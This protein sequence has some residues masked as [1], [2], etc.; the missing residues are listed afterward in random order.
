MSSLY[1]NAVIWN[2]TVVAEPA[3]LTQIPLRLS[4]N[5]NFWEDRTQAIADLP[6]GLTDKA[7]PNYS[8]PSANDAA[9]NEKYVV[10]FVDFI[11][12]MLQYIGCWVDQVAICSVAG[13]EHERCAD[14]GHLPQLLPMW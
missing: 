6:I 2:L 13:G 4:P 8:E 5:P 1:Q 9:T 12:K 10:G 11:Q 3:I 7:N 14:A